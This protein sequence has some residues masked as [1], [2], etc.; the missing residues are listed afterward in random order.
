MNTT[1]VLVAPFFG[2]PVGPILSAVPEVKTTPQVSASWTTLHTVALATPKNV[3]SVS[4]RDMLD[5]AYVI[6]CLESLY[7]VLEENEYGI[8]LDNRAKPYAD[9]PLRIASAV[10]QELVLHVQQCG[11]GCFLLSKRVVFLIKELMMQ[12]FFQ[13]TWDTF[14][15]PVPAFI[16]A[17]GDVLD[18]PRRFDL[19][20]FEN[21]LLDTKTQRW[22]RLETEKQE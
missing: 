18:I 20:F 6:S 3:A 16:A 17:N 13:K 21:Y 9:V 10:R 7:N 2:G 5:S 19:K 4:T 8:W 12:F 11:T 1:F 22:E 14:F 15:L